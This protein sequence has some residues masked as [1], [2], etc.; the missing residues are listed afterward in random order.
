[1]G[2]IDITGLPVTS[3]ELFKSAA[4]ALGLL[5]LEEFLAV[6]YPAAAESFGDCYVECQRMSKICWPLEDA[7]LQKMIPTSD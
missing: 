4:F 1:M 6:L 7:V 2:R 5:V 3:L